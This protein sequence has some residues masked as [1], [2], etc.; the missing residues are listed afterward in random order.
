MLSACYI[1][2]LFSVGFVMLSFCFSASSSM[3]ETFKD[4]VCSSIALSTSSILFPSDKA[5]LI[6]L[7]PAT[8]GLSSIVVF[9]SSMCLSTQGRK[10]IMS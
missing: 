6:S 3:S 5:S 4:P 9:V 10:Q 8:I 1:Y 7:T 2:L